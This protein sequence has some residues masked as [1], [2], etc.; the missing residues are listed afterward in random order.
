MG[1]ENI[2]EML[3]DAIAREIAVSVQYMW[4]HVQAVGIAGEVARPIFKQIAVT[5]M[6]HA[7]EIAERLNMLGGIPTTKPTTITVGTSTKNMLSLNVAAEKDA[8]QFYRKIIALAAKE[9]DYVT[10][11]MFEKILADEEGHLNDFE[12]MLEG[13]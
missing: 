3:N 9:E 13:M 5:E 7:E 2:K 8:I 10:K 6:K 11:R 4:Q 1:K 12:G